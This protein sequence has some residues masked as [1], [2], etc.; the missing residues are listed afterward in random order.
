MFLCSFLLN[1][2]GV[3][4]F[5]M[6]PD[7]SF[8]TES[9]E[10]YAIV[11][12]DGKSAHE[13]YQVLKTNSLSIFNDATKAV[14][15][16]EDVAIKIR[17]IIPVCQKIVKLLSTEVLAESKGYLS[18]E[19]KIKDERVKISAPFMENEIW[20]D[21]SSTEGNFRNLAKFWFKPEKKEKKRLENESNIAA[22]ENRINIL[23]NAVIGSSKTNNDSDD[24]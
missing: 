19:I 11:R 17:C 24:W 2:Q 22:L 4:S 20:M 23:V 7:G 12:F 21:G 13:I 16:V 8:S 3:V 14:N 18:F 6:L 9:G 15:G 1:A 5:K 10:S